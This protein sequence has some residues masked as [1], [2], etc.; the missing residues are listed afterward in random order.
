MQKAGVSVP[1]IAAI[2]GKDPRTLESWLRMGHPPRRDRRPSGS[3]LDAYRGYLEQRFAD[4]CQNAAQLW[5]ELHEQGFSGSR[6]L[7]RVW[8]GRW[9]KADPERAPYGRSA[10]PRWKA[11]S[12]HRL[13]RMLTDRRDALPD[14]DQRL[15]ER[16]LDAEPELAAT[17][18]AAQRLVQLLHRES[19]ETLDDVLAAMKVTPLQRLAISLERDKAAVQA[20]LETPWTTSPVEGQ[21]NRIKLIKR[22]MYGRAGFAL[23]RQR[24]MEAA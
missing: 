7:V 17:S 6:T 21:I 13:T 11:P 9:K 10:E 16:L 23:L 24:V 5:R 18:A 19:D 14:A 2:L 15:C 20:A 22:Q 8:I 12:T 3:I 4:G 1:G